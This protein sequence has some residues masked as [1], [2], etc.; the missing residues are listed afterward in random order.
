MI[1][2]GDSNQKADPRGLDE[3]LNTVFPIKLASMTNFVSNAK[4]AIYRCT[5]S[6]STATHY[7]TAT[8]PS[9]HSN[10]STKHMRPTEAQFTE[11]LLAPPV[12][13]EED[14]AAEALIEGEAIPI[15]V[16]GRVPIE[17]P[18]EAAPVAEAEKGAEAD[19]ETDS[20]TWAGT[21]GPV[22]R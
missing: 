9:P 10:P 2:S 8:I 18:D 22:E 13:D 7:Y 20:V 4:H 16:V 6:A 19:P 17:A 15:D 14:A 21:A 5:R 3:S 11:E 12:N 1:L